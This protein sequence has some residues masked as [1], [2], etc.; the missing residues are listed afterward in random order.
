MNGIDL[1]F[2]STDFFSRWSS[3]NTFESFTFSY[4]VVFDG[5]YTFLSMDWWIFFFVFGVLIKSLVD[6][7]FLTRIYIWIKKGIGPKHIFFLSIIFQNNAHLLNLVIFLYIELK[8]I[9]EKLLSCTCIFVVRI[10]LR[11]ESAF[12][13]LILLHFLLQFI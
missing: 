13:H 1:D 5:F 8:L 11:F 9:L 7:S 10:N 4:W 2:F 6:L 3:W 12:F